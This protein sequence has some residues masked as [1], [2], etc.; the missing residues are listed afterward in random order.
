MVKPKHP[1]CFI[2]KRLY[3]YVKIY[4]PTKG[5]H[6]FFYHSQPTHIMKNKPYS[7]TTT[8]IG[9]NYKIQFSS[10]NSWTFLDLKM[11]KSTQKSNFFF[12]KAHFISRSH[13]LFTFS[14][15]T[16]TT[17]STCEQSFQRH[18][19]TLLILSLSS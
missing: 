3:L 11:S 12:K 6:D 9:G 15:H 10:L 14:L 16:S 8:M 7:K 1:K 5:G 13:I 19:P 4:M 18:T 2:S 17:A